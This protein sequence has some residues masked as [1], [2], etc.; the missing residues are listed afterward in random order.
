[1]EQEIENTLFKL[2]FISDFN[3]GDLKKIGFSRATRTDKGVH[4]LLNTFSAK[5][6]LPKNKKDDSAFDEE[7][8]LEVIR[9]RIN[10]AITKEIKIFCLLPVSQR[11]DAKKCT[12]HRVYSYYLPTFTL[13]PI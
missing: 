6:E 2:G 11:F 4:A 12:S 9:A 5:L 13:T 1:M 7:K 8:E 10:D 3:F